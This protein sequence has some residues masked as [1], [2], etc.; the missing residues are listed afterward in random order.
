MLKI[1]IIGWYGTETL[2]DRAILAGVLKV[3]Y[4]SYCD[5]EVKL[6][7]ILPFFT[8]RTLQEDEFFLRSCCGREKLEISMFDSSSPKQLDAALHWCDCLVI[9]GGPLEDIP[10]MFMLEYAMKKAK[11]LRKRTLA[12]GC[13]VG[14][15]YKRIYQ[16]SMLQIINHADVTVFR[17]ERSRNEYLRL[18]GK[19]KDT[20]ATIDPAAFALQHYKQLYSVPQEKRDVTVVCIREF[21]PEYKMNKRIDV[22]EVN[23]KIYTYIQS[24]REQVDTSILLVPMHYFGIGDDD[25]YFMNRFYF[26]HQTENIG[27]Q[28]R[29]LTLEETMRLFMDAKYCIGMRFHSVVFQTILNGRNMIWDYTDLNSGK[30]GAFISQVNGKNFYQ[31]SY[32]NLQTDTNKPISFP[33]T[34]FV[35]PEKVIM[36]YE[37]Q[38][39]SSL[40][41]II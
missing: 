23:K 36:T 21:T 15:L 9:G 28:N 40:K 3:L 6:G 27:V 26:T 1:T 22:D 39:V 38:Y 14:P 11:K 20:I 10:S 16:K 19:N 34:S 7:T 29:V 35:V 41:Y 25:R 24:L 30:I 4:T 32:L 13:G 31:K 17:D 8:E 33:E 2:G 12:L 37:Q 5:L 18:G